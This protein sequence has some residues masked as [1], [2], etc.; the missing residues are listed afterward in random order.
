MLPIAVRF[1]LCVFARTKGHA[2]ILGHFKPERL[3][4]CSSMRTI[5]KR[6]ASSPPAT[7]PIIDSGLELQYA[8]FT[9]GNYW[10]G[11]F[12]IRSE[13]FVPRLLRYFLASLFV[14]FA[15]GTSSVVHY[16]SYFISTFWSF[17]L[18]WFLDLEH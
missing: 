14:L 17:Y 6:L 3:K 9:I 12:Y 4:I 1:M 2:R 13:G 8:W 15:A 18:G 7:A 11:H 10:L 5:T 16:A